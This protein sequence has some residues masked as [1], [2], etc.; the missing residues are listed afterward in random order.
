MKLT[1]ITEFKDNKNLTCNNSIV[2]YE[3][4]PPLY[5]VCIAVTTTPSCTEYISLFDTPV[6]S[7][8]GWK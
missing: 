1:K 4:L 5:P 8:A 3:P 2:T 7:S 6:I